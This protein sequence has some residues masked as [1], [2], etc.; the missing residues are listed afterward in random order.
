[1]WWK[2]PS[3]CSSAEFGL[4]DHYDKPSRKERNVGPGSI[5]AGADW[6]AATDPEESC[7]MSVTG[8]RT[9]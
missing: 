3:V 9:L 2:G 6:T 5:Y 7:G 4:S 1:M 8:K